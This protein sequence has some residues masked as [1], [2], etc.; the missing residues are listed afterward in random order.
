MQ[1][2]IPPY[3]AASLPASDA[4]DET[5]NG[6]THRGCWRCTGDETNHPKEKYCFLGM[7]P[8]IQKKIC[9]FFFAIPR[10]SGAASIVFFGEDGLVGDLFGWTLQ[11]VPCESAGSDSDAERWPCG[12]TSGWGYPRGSDGWWFGCHFL[13]FPI[14]I[15]LL[16]IPIDFHIFQRGGPTTNQIPLMDNFAIR[17]PIFSRDFP[18]AMLDDPRIGRK[19]WS[20]S[21]TWP[22]RRVSQENLATVDLRITAVFWLL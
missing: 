4:G 22:S 5:T 16:I 3:P 13:N 1:K 6:T 19:L 10:I 7:K 18:L 14:N 17:T 2:S 20:R 21:T 12:L 9:C 15:G 11:G 8:T